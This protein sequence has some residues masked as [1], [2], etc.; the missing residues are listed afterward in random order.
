MNSDKCHLFVSGQKYEHLWAKIDNDKIWEARTVKLLGITIDNELKFDE[1][2]NNVC[3]KANMKLSAVMRLRKYLHFNKTRILFKGCFE[4]QF[5]YCPLT[6]MFYSRNTN[7][8]LNQLHERA[9]RLVYDNYE[10]LFEKLLEKDGSFTVHH[11][12]IQTLCTELSKVYHNIAQIIFSDLFI[13]SNNNYNIRAKSDFVIPQINTVLK[14][15]NSIR[16][17]GL[18]IWNLVPAELKYVD[19]LETFKRKIRMW[20]P[21]N[22]PCRIC[23]NYIHT[24]G[25]FQIFE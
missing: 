23:K 7:N 19:S 16:Y 22:Y 11:Y 5:K 14:G 18:L 9:L 21:K 12:N 10:L 17:Y 3:L 6:W 2:S 13:R 8:K 25:F 1:H 20:K 15:S 24:V 4:S